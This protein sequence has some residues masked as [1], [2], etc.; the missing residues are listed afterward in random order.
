MRVSLVVFTLNEIEGMKVIMPEIKQLQ[1]LG[2]I[3]EILV[4]DGGSTDGTL[5]YCKYAGYPSFIQKG[6]GSGAAFNEAMERITGDAV[7]LFA[8]DGNSP[9]EIIPEIV[10]NLNLDYDVITVSRYLPPAKSYDDDSLTA[11]GNWMFSKIASFLFRYKFTDVLNM[12]MGVTVD[13]IASQK[14]TEN[15]K[16][17]WASM[18]KMR[19]VRSGRTYI[20][21]PGDEPK[22]IGGKRK[23][24]PL[25]NGF[26]E[27]YMICKE[28]FYHPK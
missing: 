25:V 28:F 7:I 11:F 26:W 19:A 15:T 3:D 6:K 12:Y 21:I 17:S 9:P 1:K 22:R 5:E 24:R 23:L 10:K 18:M 13:F 2:W 4:A 16:V 20:E 8:P 27:S 14:I